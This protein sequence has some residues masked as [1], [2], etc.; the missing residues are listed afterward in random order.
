[1]YFNYHKTKLEWWNNI[2]TNKIKI[3]VSFLKLFQITVTQTKIKQQ[4]QK[5]SFLLQVK[6]FDLYIALSLTDCVLYES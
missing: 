5:G 2:A 6:S 1:M 3:H 4:Q